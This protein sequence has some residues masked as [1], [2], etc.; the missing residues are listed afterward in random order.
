ME[1]NH[2][3]TPQT[4]QS[5]TTEKNHATINN[6]EAVLAKNQELLGKLSKSKTE[7][8]ELRAFKAD[9]ELKQKEAE[10][11]QSEVIQS[12]REQIKEKDDKLTRVVQ[13][14]GDRIVKEN[15]KTLAVKEGVK[16]IA[17]FDR[18][19][20]RELLNSVEIQDDFSVNADDLQRVVDSVKEGTKS[21]GLFKSASSNHNPVTS[22]NPNVPSNNK[23][24]KD[25]TAE[26]MKQAIINEHS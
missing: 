3:V 13:G 15:L 12:L 10:G 18:F 7:L 14:F 4:Q 5:T 25:M 6:P 16:D 8:E 23:S 26:E 22:V 9:M 1:Q 24:F 20:D 21:I 11:K 2:E 19:L 17:V